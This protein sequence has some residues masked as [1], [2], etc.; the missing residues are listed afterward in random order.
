MNQNPEKSLAPCE[1][2]ET[3]PAPLGF[4]KVKDMD[5]P[6]NRQVKFNTYSSFSGLDLLSQLKEESK[7]N[8]DSGTRSYSLFGPD[9]PNSAIFR[10]PLTGR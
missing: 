5:K 10:S 6:D 4:T 3:S 2:K 9:E 7:L 1:T 8:S